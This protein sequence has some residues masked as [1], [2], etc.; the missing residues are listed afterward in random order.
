MNTFAFIIQTPFTN[1]DYKRFGVDLLLNRGISVDV[2]DLTKLINPKYLDL[3]KV[4]DKSLYKN[5]YQISSVEQFESYVKNN[6][7]VIY[8]NF[9]HGNPKTYFVYRIY[10]K[11][12]SVYASFTANALPAFTKI[13]KEPKLKKISKI[14]NFQI[15][16][17][18][19]SSRLFKLADKLEII[20]KPAF[21]LAGGDAKTNY[22]PTPTKKSK[23]IYA[24]TL[25]Y[26]LYLE[27]LR[28][29]NSKDSSPKYAVF[30]DEYLPL[31]PDF[32]VIGDRFKP[33]KNNPELYFNEMR[34]IFDAIEKEIKM[35]IVIAAHPR[36]K[37]KDTDKFYGEREIVN[38]RTIELVAGSNIVLLH[39]STS[40]N[41]SV[42]FKKPMVFILPKGL[43]G[44]FYDD[45]ISGFSRL[46]GVNP[47]S[48]NNSPEISNYI[49]RFGKAYEEYKQKYIKTK[50][51]PDK[52]FW[53]IVSDEIILRDK[54]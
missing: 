2:L 13:I 43:K 8:I 33:Y 20:Q 46:F 32:I 52:Y 4:E 37:Y 39:C 41:F 47:Y 45:Q 19:I 15:L 9:I 29:N 5:I 54:K 38:G 12:N 22:L 17:E 31:H 11:Y 51:S 1:R 30:L 35:P 53:E 28:K 48:G 24:H 40:I 18:I 34:Y 25:D 3:Y 50:N 7:E 16:K 42:L 10:K 21:V 27:Y 14:F 6:S 36:A 44:G 49:A 23:I 26:D